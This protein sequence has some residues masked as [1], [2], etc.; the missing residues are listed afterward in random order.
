MTTPAI[1]G[2]EQLLKAA[3]EGYEHSKQAWVRAKKNLDAIEYEAQEW[4]DRVISLQR[5]L[6]T[7]KAEAAKPVDT[8]PE[9]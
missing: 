8:T 7:R 9:A 4:S 6:D 1:K 2:V 5:A 3:R